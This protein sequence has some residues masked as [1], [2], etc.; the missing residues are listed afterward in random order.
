MQ[1]ILHKLKKGNVRIALIDLKQ[2]S[3]YL[4]LS[5]IPKWFMNRYGRKNS[6]E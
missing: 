4:A 2:S 3:G 6:V 1:N 5:I